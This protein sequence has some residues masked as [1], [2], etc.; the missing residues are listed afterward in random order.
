MCGRFTLTSPER[1][2]REVL[3]RE[4]EVEEVGEDPAALA[5]RF[6]I[7]PTQAVPIVRA[8]G[9]DGGSRGSGGGRE[10]TFLT[11]GLV[12]TGSRNA[13]K[14]AAAK[15]INARAE[16]L[17][18]RPSYRDAFRLRRCLVPA[19]GFY[20]W[21]DGAGKGIRQPWWI[22]R[23]DGGPFAFAGLWEGGTFSIVTREARGAI[24]QLHARTPVML[25]ERA[26][27]GLWLDPEV[28]TN[29]DG[30]IDELLRPRDAGDVV[31]HAVSRRVNRNDFEDPSAVV[32]VTAPEPAADAAAGDSEPAQ[33]SLF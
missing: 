10:L 29:A 15:M 27:R 32:E 33:R 2:I 24:R 16:T 19:D 12:P 28:D 3:E 1:A 11:W 5:P 14:S 13:D 4:P 21:T 31:F 23:A 17:R 22:H 7:A 26:A 6:N 20:E 30:P 8:R 9:V 18:E 25:F